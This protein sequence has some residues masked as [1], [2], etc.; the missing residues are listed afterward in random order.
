MPCLYATRSPLVTQWVDLSRAR[1][2]RPVVCVRH[3]RCLRATGR[4]AILVAPRS[5]FGTGERS[6]GG[7]LVNSRRR[8]LIRAPI[9]LLSVAVACRE[10]AATPAPNAGGQTTGAPP[11]TPGAPPTFASAPS[12]GPA[13]TPA[14]F[15]DAEKLAQV[16]M[17][18]AQRRQAADSWGKAMAPYYERRTG[19]RTLALEPTLA[20][21]THWNPVLGGGPVGPMRDRFVR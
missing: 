1:R 20:P 18:D 11:A 14:T 4:R 2:R 12:V 8:F 3:W 10:H 5:R 15:A 19:P 9:G 17:T 13:V 6:F 16:T 7:P 21:A